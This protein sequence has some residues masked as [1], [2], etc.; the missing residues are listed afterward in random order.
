[1]MARY[2]KE[3]ADFDFLP[4]HTSTDAFD[5]RRLSVRIGVTGWLSDRDTSPTS[6]WEIFDD[7]E[8]CYVLRWEV[9]ALKN[10]GRAMRAMVFSAALGYAQK[11]VIRQTFLAGIW[12]AVAI[13]VGMLQFGRIV[14]NPWRIGMVRAKKVSFCLFPRLLRLEISLPML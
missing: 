3:V 4:I 2:S 5:A 8:D 12:T 11:E 13:P 7:S 9:E 14:D 10:L 1:M 6:P